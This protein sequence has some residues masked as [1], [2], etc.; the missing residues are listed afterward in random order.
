MKAILK[1]ILAFFSN[2]DEKTDAVVSTEPTKPHTDN[3]EFKL[4]SKEDRLNNRCDKY[5]FIID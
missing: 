3:F 2:S 5:E 1:H 4:I